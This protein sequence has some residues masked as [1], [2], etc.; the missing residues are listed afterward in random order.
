MTEEARFFHGVME[1]G[2]AYNAHARIQQGGAALALALLE[3]VIRKMQF[4]SSGRPAVI[5]DYGSSQGKN[6]LAPIRRAVETLRTMLGSDRPILVFHVDLPANDFNSLFEVL[7]AAPDRYERSDPQVFPCA[8]GRSFYRNVLPPHS[9]NV[10]WSAFA[11]VWLSRIPATVPGHFVVFRSSGEVRATFERQAADD[12][13]TFLS[14]RAKELRPGGRFV[15]LLP[16]VDDDGLTGFEDLFDNVNEVLMTMVEEG[17][18]RAEERTRI[19]LGGYPRRRCELLAPFQRDGQFEQ[20]MV[21]QCDMS[22]LKDPAWAEYERQ[23]DA[24]TLARKH[25]LFFRSTFVPSLASALAPGR[26]R[27]EQQLFADRLEAGLRKRLANHPAPV[28]SFVQTLV[29]A[30]QN[31][32]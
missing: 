26:C 12:W 6:S 19:V 1:G 23:R 13:K 10:G 27:A 22:V 4:D 20:L 21:E 31:V 5:A 28:H 30:K 32:T 17:A 3:S 29:L 8:I 18:I 14:R 15:L 9:V 25:A 2:G 24:E 7:D 16:G 11:A